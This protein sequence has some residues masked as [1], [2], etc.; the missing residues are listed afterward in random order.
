M[1]GCERQEYQLNEALSCYQNP[2]TINAH[3]RAA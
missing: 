3:A 2:E 1:Y